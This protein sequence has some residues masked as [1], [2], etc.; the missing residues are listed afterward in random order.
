MEPPTR[1]SLVSRALPITDSHRA[2]ASFAVTPVRWHWS[3]LRE[4][5]SDNILTK[6]VGSHYIKP[7]FVASGHGDE[8]LSFH[9]ALSVPSR[10]SAG[11]PI[12]LL[13]LRDPRRITAAR[14]LPLMGQ[15]SLWLTTQYGQFPRRIVPRFS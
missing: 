7:A 12:A 6:D 2:L 11:L 8:T 4:S 1:Q 15:E 9:A 3:W 5:N 10:G 14:T 13:D